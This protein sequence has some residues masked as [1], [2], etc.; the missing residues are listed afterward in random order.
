MER[1][2]GLAWWK[3][4]RFVGVIIH[5]IVVL[6]ASVFGVIEN[7]SSAGMIISAA[8]G[9]VGLAHTA[10]ATSDALTKRAEAYSPNFPSVATVPPGTIT[11]PP[12]D[13]SQNKGINL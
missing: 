11:P 3:S 9:A 4:K 5:D 7:P 2:V 1:A 12:I 8:I 6:F 13:P 10:H